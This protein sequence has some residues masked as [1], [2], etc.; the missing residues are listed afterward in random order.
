MS[1]KV[2][3][4]SNVLWIQG[5]IIANCVQNFLLPPDPTILGPHP[6]NSLSVVTSSLMAPLHMQQ[7]RKRASLAAQR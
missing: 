1:L 3:S 6:E 5:S 2:L 7:L 4:I